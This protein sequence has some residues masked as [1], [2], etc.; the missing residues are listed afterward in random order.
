[1]PNR[2]AHAMTLR[3][4]VLVAIVSATVLIVGLLVHLAHSSRVFWSLDETSRLSNSITTAVAELDQLVYEYMLRPHSRPAEQ[5]MKLSHQL[6]GLIDGLEQAGGDHL[7]LERLRT[8]QHQAQGLFESIVHENA[9]DVAPE[10]ANLRRHRVAEQLLI[11]SR[12]LVNQAGAIHRT[13]LAQQSAIHLRDNAFTVAVLSVSIGLL[14]WLFAYFHRQVLRRLED[15]QRRTE[16]AAAG[17][18]DLLLADRRKDELGELS[19]AF[20]RMLEQLRSSRDLRHQEEALRASEERLRQLIDA[21]PVLVWAAQPDGAIDVYNRAWSELLGVDPT[22][23][24][25]SWE[26]L[27][28]IE[29]LGRWRSTWRQAITTGAAIEI[30]VRLR[31]RE[32]WCWHLARVAPLSAR[33]GRIVRW[34][35]TTADIQQH[36]ELEERLRHSRNQAE[37]LNQ[38]GLDLVSEIDIARL[39]QRV[40]D[41]ATALATAEFGMLFCDLA[42]TGAGYRPLA[43]SGLPHEAV[44]EFPAPSPGTMF[45][46]SFRGVTVIRCDDVRGDSR[47]ANAGVMP[48]LPAGYPPVASY[49]AV[50]LRTRAGE[51]IGALFCCHPQPAH[52]TVQH[53][54][55]VSGI[56]ALAATAFDNARLID[57]ERRQRRLV[58]ERAA[59]LARSNAE[60]EQFAYICSHD[61]QEPLRMVSSFLGLL[62]ERYQGQLDE[63]GRGFILRAIDGASRMQNLIRDILSF[64]R[65]GR[66]ERA[67]ERFTLADTVADALANLQVQIQQA[68]ARIEIGELPMVR[69]NRLQCV[70]LFQNL[71]SNAIK[72]RGDQP[73]LV[74]INASPQGAWWRIEVADN[75]IGIDPAHHRRVFQIFQRLHGREQFEGT[76]IGLS[77]CEKIVLAHGGRIGVDSTVGHGATFWFTLPDAESSAV[78]STPSGGHPV[79]TGKVQEQ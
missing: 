4:T 66:G 26:A 44:A 77:L 50:P 5:W 49:L 9:A 31:Q 7:P 54:R 71:I 70:Q 20:D 21:L 56:A 47:F 24:G 27:V 67:E 69:G 52:F 61:L 16:R 39:A 57:M 68:G 8:E 3:R 12:S 32:Q 60:L 65:V 38:V 62:S 40:T 51:V 37:L 22:A 48:A 29:D 45:R 43:L 64:S 58:D 46:P 76:G 63:R 15:V 74:R 41:T 42:S 2:S 25:F 34:V 17:D 28:H 19:R 33:N 11:V 30:E 78:T 35:G 23:P 36:K 6:D 1:M 73:P 10:V 14:I 13:S 53:E 72:F 79:L 18:L 75:G 59:A 55:L